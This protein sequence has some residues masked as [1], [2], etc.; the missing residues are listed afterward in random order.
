MD[1]IFLMKIIK[2][3]KSLKDDSGASVLSH[4]FKQF[5]LFKNVPSLNHPIKSIPDTYSETT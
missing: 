2:S 1:D 5:L 3:E 4:V